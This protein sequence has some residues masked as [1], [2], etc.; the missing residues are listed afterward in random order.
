M[1]YAFSYASPDKIN[2]VVLLFDTIL[3]HHRFFTL[4][5]SYMITHDII[6]M[7]MLHNVSVFQN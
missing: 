4:M 7:M 6:S 2:V 1:K 5:T 3:K